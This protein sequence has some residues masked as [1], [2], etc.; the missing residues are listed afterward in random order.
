MFR[1]SRHFQPTSALVTSGFTRIREPT[2]A[3]M[4]IPPAYAS[5][6]RFPRAGGFLRL[7]SL[8]LSFFG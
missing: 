7:R 5:R 4:L 2:E 6:V 1:V 8:S 3:G